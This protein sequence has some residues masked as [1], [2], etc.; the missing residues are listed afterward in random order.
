[1]IQYRQRGFLCFNSKANSSSF[2]LIC[3]PT[4]L[5]S[6]RV[7]IENSHHEVFQG[8]YYF[9]DY[10][11]PKNKRDMY[12]DHPVYNQ[13]VNWCENYDQASFDPDYPSLPLSTFYPTIERI[14]ARP[15]YWWNPAHPKA[16]A[17]S[18]ASEL[19]EFITL[20]KSVSECTDTWQCYDKL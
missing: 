15:Q 14:L 13:T 10:G 5:C 7:G 17:V 6:M 2:L 1:M 8:F 16:G 9:E 12:I 4:Y 19:N 18:S 20:G 11:I 3:C